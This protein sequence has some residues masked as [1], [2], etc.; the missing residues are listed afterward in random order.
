VFPEWDGSYIKL[1][2]VVYEKKDVF[3]SILVGIAPIIVGIF[4]LWWMY[5]INIFAIKNTFFQVILIAF[6]F[7][8]SSSMFSSKQDLVDIVYILPI[9]I[10]CLGLLYIF[11][12]PVA[13]IFSNPEFIAGL[14]SFMYAINTY[15]GISIGIHI[16]LIAVLRSGLYIF[17]KR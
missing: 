17:R 4:I 5:E 2:R 14:R 12:I 11:D 16:V 7:I 10:L 1:G 6:I 8:L 15:L 13:R 9:L 3:R